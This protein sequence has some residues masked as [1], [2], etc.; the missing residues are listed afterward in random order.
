MEA[1]M[2][3]DEIFLNAVE[4]W[5]TNKGVGTMICPV[6][7]NDKVPLFWMFT[8]LFFLILI[9]E[10]PPLVVSLSSKSF[11]TFLFIKLM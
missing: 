7:L 5:R 3:I 11:I 8:M 1:T 10:H 9:T 2:T 4:S 6:P